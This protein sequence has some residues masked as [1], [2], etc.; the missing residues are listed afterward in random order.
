M[1]KRGKQSRN[2]VPLTLLLLKIH[3]IYTL[4]TIVVKGRNAMFNWFD[5]LGAT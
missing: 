2:T 4:Y 3:I 1:K 5:S